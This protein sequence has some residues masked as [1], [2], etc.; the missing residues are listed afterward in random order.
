VRGLFTTDSQPRVPHWARLLDP[1]YS[2]GAWQSG[3]AAATIAH[4]R[5]WADDWRLAGHN[6]TWDEG[7]QVSS[8][9]AANQ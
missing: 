3:A 1:A 4:A 6:A 7:S 9:T 5:R 8:S 2:R